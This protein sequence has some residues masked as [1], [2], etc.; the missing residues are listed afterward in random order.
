MARGGGG[1][2][3]DLGSVLEDLDEELDGLRLLGPVLG[4]ARVDLLQDA[5]LVPQNLPPQLLD[6]SRREERG[7]GIVAKSG[8]RPMGKLPGAGHTRRRQ[9]ADKRLLSSCQTHTHVD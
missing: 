1:R 2:G 5:L 4:R 8:H 6:S 3:V 7:C 9:G